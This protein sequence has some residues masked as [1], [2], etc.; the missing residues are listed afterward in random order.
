VAQGRRRR[1]ESTIL[2]SES[3]VKA[4]Q[5][6]TE[7]DQKSLTEIIQVPQLLG[8]WCPSVEMQGKGWLSCAG[9]QELQLV[10]VWC[11]L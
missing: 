2:E 3:L 11:S 7:M 6:Q 5:Q 10:G 1:A 9:L 8:R 4:L